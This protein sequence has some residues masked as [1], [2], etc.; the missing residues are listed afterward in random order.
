MACQFTRRLPE[1]RKNLHAAY[2][3]ADVFDIECGEQWYPKAQGI[4][5]DW[6]SHYR[7]HDATVACVIAAISPQCDWPHNLIIADDVLADRPVSVGGALHVNIAKAR[8][9]RDTSGEI[10]AGSPVCRMMREV[11]PCGP[12]V[13]A[14][15]QNLA[16][17]MSVVTIDGHAM[18]AALNDPRADYRLKWNAYAVFAQAY[19]EVAY[20]VGRSAAEF[21][22]I[23][24]HVWK[25]EYPRE[26]KRN[27][28]RQ[29]SV[30][31]EF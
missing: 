14:F 27:L 6:A 2:L 28:R 23:I 12:K 13:N 1:L 24:W 16:G 5:R 25:S 22:A 31:G 11:F 15:A 21:Q 30:I 17:N 20:E 26:V 3:R 4:V 9:L 7:L 19:Q 18:Q 29:W 10:L 8:R